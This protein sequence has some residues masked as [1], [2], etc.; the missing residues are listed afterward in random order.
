MSKPIQQNS[1]NNTLRAVV[2]NTDGSIK[3]DLA[4]NTTGI[5]IYV[6]KIGVADGS[7]MTLSAKSGTTWAA[8]AFLNLGGGDVSVD[9][10]DAV[11]A[12]FLGE[13]RIYGTFTGGTI[14]GTWYP[15]VA[16]NPNAVA[17][18]ANTIAP[19]NAAIA[20]IRTKAEDVIAE[21]AQSSAIIAE[22]EDA[23]M[24]NVSPLNV[25]VVRDD[26]DE[27]PIRFVW[28]TDDATITVRRS[29]NAGAYEAASGT[30][31]FFR[32]EGNEH[33]YI[34]AY[35]AAD[36]AAGIVRYEFTDGVV[37]RFVSLN[38]V[39]GSSA[40]VGE[41]LVPFTIKNALSAIVPYCSV[42]VT[43]SSE[44][45]AIEV[46]DEGTSNSTGRVEF[47]LNPGTYYLWRNKANYEFTDPVEFAVSDEGVVT[48]S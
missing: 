18:G 31:S 37:T 5:S 46:I 26:T 25:A 48:V 39:E 23:V 33:W 47:K 4:F 1:T 13:V 30:V 16:Y 29:I 28:P 22:I 10:A 41:F 7:A 43:A 2:Y 6:Q 3:T 36:R 35:N 11:F 34:L 20:L 15:V 14:V 24:I 42:T 32:T 38:V 19:D 21:T 9:V 45:S 12:S 8:G 27:T 17:V 44:G 40:D